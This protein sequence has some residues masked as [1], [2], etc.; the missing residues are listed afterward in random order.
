V[1]EHL[2]DFQIERLDMFGGEVIVSRAAERVLEPA[3]H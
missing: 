1:R 3:H 2:G